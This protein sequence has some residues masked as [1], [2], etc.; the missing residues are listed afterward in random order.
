VPDEPVPDVQQTMHDEIRLVLPADP[1]YGRVARVAASGLAARLG[2]SW[3][4]VEDLQIAVDESLIVLLHPEGSGGEVTFTFLVEADRLV[5]DAVTTAGAHQFWVDQAARSRFE[6]IVGPML[7]E[8]EIDEAGNR[9]HL[10]KRLHRP[11]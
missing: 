7:D 5:I 9:V 11:V 8:H 3:P 1:D 10:V 2:L 6:Q 4:E